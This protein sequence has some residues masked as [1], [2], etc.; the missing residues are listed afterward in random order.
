MDYSTYKGFMSD[1]MNP[2]DY[3]SSSPSCLFKEIAPQYTDNAMYTMEDFDKDGLPSA[4][5]IFM[6]CDTEYEAAIK[7]VGSWQ[8]WLKL[9]RNKLFMDGGLTSQWGGLDEW[10]LERIERDKSLAKAQLM[11][12]ARSGNV[13]AQRTV[14]EDKDKLGPNKKKAT[15]SE[16]KQDHILEEANARLKLIK[17]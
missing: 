4:R 5:R 8:G 9:T 11:K 15:Q 14:Y 1:D 13:S 6:A 16:A 12:A 2:R 17:K 7:L 3:Y 10:R